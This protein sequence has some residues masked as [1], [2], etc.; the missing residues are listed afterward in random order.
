MN[1]AVKLGVAFAVIT[2]VGLLALP[3]S[4]TK[5]A[6]ATPVS[7]V[8]S[9]F[10]IFVGGTVQITATWIDDGINISPPVCDVIPCPDGPA[11]LGAFHSTAAGGDFVPSTC[12]SSANLTANSDGQ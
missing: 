2:A 7:V 3:G 6:Q 5:P 12:Q 9:S 11:I 10:T 4:G 1:R 8:P